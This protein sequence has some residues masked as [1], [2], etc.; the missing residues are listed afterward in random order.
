MA[1]PQLLL[2]LRLRELAATRV[3]YGYRR[4]H[5]LL[6]REG[7]QINPKR[8]YRFYR[9]EGLVMR[10]KLPR[11]RGCSVISTS[12]E[13]GTIARYNKPMMSYP[14]TVLERIYGKSLYSTAAAQSDAWLIDNFDPDVE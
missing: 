5:V 13:P 7:W 9:A 12:E 11:A 6:R 3:A 10:Q 2:R 1:D 14:E 4:L 8:V